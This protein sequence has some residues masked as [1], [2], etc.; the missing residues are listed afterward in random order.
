MIDTTSPDAETAAKWAAFQGYSL[1]LTESDDGTRA[2]FANDAD[3]ECH[4]WAYFGSGSLVEAVHEAMTYA[5]RDRGF[6]AAFTEDCGVDYCPFCTD[7]P[8]PTDEGR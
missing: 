2:V 7:R 6:D 3:A 1:N 4:K 8:F 5:V